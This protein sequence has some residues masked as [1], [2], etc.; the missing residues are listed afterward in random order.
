VLRVF[1]ELDIEQL[2]PMVRDFLLA[3]EGQSDFVWN[4]QP[5]DEVITDEI[6]QATKAY[7]LVDEDGK[8]LAKYKTLASAEQ[9]AAGAKVTFQVDVDLEETGDEI[10][11]EDE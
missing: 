9:A 2:S 7:H 3:F 6:M 1:R 10:P 8:V 11:D 4:D 5:R